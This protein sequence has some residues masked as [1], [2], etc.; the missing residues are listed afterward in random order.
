MRTA[1]AQYFC[2]RYL[3]RAGRERPQATAANSRF[4]PIFTLLRIECH[5]SEVS[6]NFVQLAFRPHKRAYVVRSPLRIIAFPLKSC[7]VAAGQR[8]F[9][10]L[11]Q[12]APLDVLRL[13][14]IVSCPRRRGSRLPA[15]S[16]RPPG[17][18]RDRR[19]MPV[20]RPVWTCPFRSASQ[21]VPA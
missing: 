6:S 15:A 3:V 14:V 13:F 21:A 19:R 10:E 17:A 1:A 11:G 20:L 7:V 8:R 5:V 16:M 12:T 4:M 18:R 9:V 2:G